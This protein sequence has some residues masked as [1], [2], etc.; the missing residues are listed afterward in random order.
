MKKLY[1]MLFLFYVASAN[2]NLAEQ[3]RW[4]FEVLLDEKRIGYHDFNVS[5]VDGVQTVTTEARFDVKLLFVNVFSY[6]HKNTEVWRDN[7]L[8]SISAETASNGKDFI[9]RGQADAETF[10]MR[11]GS[12]DNELPACIM[13]FAYWNPEFL[14]ADQLLNSQTGEY[15]N[16]S[17]VI[18]GEEVLAVKGQDIQAIK[19]SLSL[20]AGPISLWYAADDHRWLALESIVKG[21]KVLRYEPVILPRTLGSSYALGG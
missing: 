12:L 11:S 19:Y 3:A 21:G 17:V 1:L 20:A 10:R 2:A 8:T 18:E 15:E 7:C 13:T 6:R 9:V 14:R 16:V 4:E 5:E